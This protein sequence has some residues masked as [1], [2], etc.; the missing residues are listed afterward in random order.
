M[1]LR[2]R[3]IKVNTFFLLLYQIYAGVKTGFINVIHIT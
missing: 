2:I 1:F 3:K